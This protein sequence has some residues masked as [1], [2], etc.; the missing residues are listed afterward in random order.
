MTTSKVAIVTGA[1]GDIGAGLVAGYRRRDWAVVASARS[2]G[3][4]RDPDLLTVAADVTELATA[5]QV[6][7]TALERFGRIDTLVNNAGVV[8]SKPFTGYTAADYATVVGVGITGF[9]WL[10]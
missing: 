4:S 7:D 8:I 6:I 3:P 5:G 9:F 10:T 2:I 1:S